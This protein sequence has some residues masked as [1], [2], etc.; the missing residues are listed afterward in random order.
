MTSERRAP[1]TLPRRAVNPVIRGLTGFPLA[2]AQIGAGLFGA[3]G[4]PARAQ[5]RIA[6]RFGRLAPASGRP[7]NLRSLGHG[8][9]VLVPSLIGFF[10]AVVVVYLVWA[11]WLYPLRPDTFGY[12]S[13]PFTVDHGLDGS[14]GGP[15]LIGAWFI[16]AMSSLGMQLVCLAA[17]TGLTRLQDNL[18]RRL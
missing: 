5:H 14:W 12:L 6:A 18:T 2:L 4:A 17:I 16:H 1:D 10:L 13:H 9:A 15:T 3:A 8:L 11:G 7:G